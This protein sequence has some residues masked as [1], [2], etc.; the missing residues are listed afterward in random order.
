MDIPVS[1]IGTVRSA[2][3]TASSRLVLP[4]DI[5][6]ETDGDPQDANGT[7]YLP[8]AAIAWKQSNGFYYP[9][10]FHSDQLYFQNVDIRHFV[11]EPLFNYGTFTTD[12]TRVKTRYCTWQT[13]C[14]T[15]S[16]TSIG[17]P[18]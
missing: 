10:A 5:S 14:S 15:I 6:T 18:F 3:P 7:C 16:P 2:R 11:I 12:Q 1:D 9:P 13:V 4:S 8:N 17:R